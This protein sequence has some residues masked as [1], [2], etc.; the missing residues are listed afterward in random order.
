MENNIYAHFTV[1]N[2]ISMPF[3]LIDQFYFIPSLFC[4]MC[5]QSSFHFKEKFILMQE[6]QHMKYTAFKTEAEAFFGA[7]SS[8][9][10]DEFH[11]Q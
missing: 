5:S 3:L 11:P 2:W 4:L 6:S 8:Q 9:H 1:P 10:R 7:H